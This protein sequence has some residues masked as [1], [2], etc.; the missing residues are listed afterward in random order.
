MKTL[1]AF[2]LVI[3][4]FGCNQDKAK[5]QSIQTIDKSLTSLF[6]TLEENNRL[7]F[8]RVVVNFH[9]QSGN[10]NYI[11]RSI[12]ELYD[13]IDVVIEDLLKE[14]GGY[15][16]ET[17]A[18][19]GGNIKGLPLQLVKRHDFLNQVKLKYSEIKV[20]SE[21]QTLPYHKEVL[22]DLEASLYPILSDNWGD[23]VLKNF[24]VAKLYLGLMIVQNRLLVAEVKYYE[25]LNQKERSGNKSRS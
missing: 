11:N 19:I 25:M 5:N 10:S 6:Y 9:L 16:P 24:T 22:K 4:F 2:A 8:R 15:N 20:Y 23:N 14:S 13:L 12:I 17:A 1:S 21:N 18:L 7:E 3:L